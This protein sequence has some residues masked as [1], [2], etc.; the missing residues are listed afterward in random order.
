M[1]HPGTILTCFWPCWRH[2]GLSWRADRRQQSS[3][4]KVRTSP[5]REHRFVVAL[6]PFFNY[7]GVIAQLVALES[8]CVIL[9]AHSSSSVR[10][11]QF[12]LSA[13]DT[14]QLL[15]VVAVLAAWSRIKPTA[16]VALIGTTLCEYVCWLA[17]MAISAPESHSPLA[18]IHCDACFLTY[19][20]LQQGPCLR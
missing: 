2:V 17:T 20:G 12:V 15:H 13:Y 16:V 10:S 9:L 5:T 18:V 1:G 11:L 14:H 3:F 8:I 6:T 7:L 19:A 4:C